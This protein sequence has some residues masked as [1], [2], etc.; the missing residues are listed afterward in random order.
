MGVSSTGNLAYSATL[1]HR[2]LELY[3]TVACFWM[4]GT[5]LYLVSY[6]WFFLP[7]LTSITTLKGSGI[8]FLTTLAP[9]LHS[10]IQTISG[11]LITLHDL[12]SS[13]MGIFLPL[14]RRRTHCFCNVNISDDCD[15]FNILPHTPKLYCKWV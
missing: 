11:N 13:S 5:F 8:V 15:L 4:L 2:K 12:N 3:C 1:L 14:P 6:L 10:S 9:N 7:A